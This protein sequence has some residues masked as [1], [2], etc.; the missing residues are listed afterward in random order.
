MAASLRSELCL[1]SPVGLGFRVEGLGFR[2]SRIG[3]R[4]AV[5]KS[6]SKKGFR[7]SG[8]RV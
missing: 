2:V 1:G 6:S 5:S 7:V 8:F 3:G 4:L